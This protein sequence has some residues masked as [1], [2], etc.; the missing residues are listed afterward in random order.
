M[1]HSWCSSD[2]WHHIARWLHTRLKFNAQGDSCSTVAWSSATIVDTLKELQKVYPPQIFYHK[3]KK[4]YNFFM[5]TWKWSL[6]KCDL[7]MARIHTAF[8]YMRRMKLKYQYVH[9]HPMLM[10]LILFAC[11]LVENGLSFPCTVHLSGKDLQG[12]LEKF[13]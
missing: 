4:R 6:L 1:F 11:Y 5:L 2:Q 3:N 8:N 9:F 10:E 12:L 13:V 7:W